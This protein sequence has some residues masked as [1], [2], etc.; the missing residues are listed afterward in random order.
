M[1]Q[2]LFIIHLPLFLILSIVCF[3]IPGVFLLEKIKIK[4]SFWEKII[5]G[6][7]I[8][9]IFFTLLS[10]SLL[11][12][13][14]H[15][16]LLPA[17]FSINLFAI[18]KISSLLNQIKFL[19]KYNLII[20]SLVFVIGVI[21]QLL[22]IA[23]S[24]IYQNGD[25]VFWSS[26]G[27][28]GLWHISLMEE[29]KK[30]YPL[31][32]PSLSGE[33]L[34]NYHFFSDIAPAEFNRYFKVPPLDLYF[35]FF[36]FIFS[37]LLGSLAYLLGKKMGGS[38][39]S[40]LWSVIFTYF[41]GSFGYIV[42]IM[43]NRTIGGES[44][45]WSS[46]PQ[47]SIGNP[48]QI[49]AFVIVL[50]FLYLFS[51]FVDKGGKVLLFLCALLAGSLA[52][53]KIYGATVLLISLFLVGLWQLFRERKL[54]LLFIFLMSSILA[55][56][57]YFPNSSNAGSFLIFEP[58]WFIRTMVVA[59]DRLNWLDL[60]LKRQTYIFESNWKRVV[61]V[62]LT[63]FVIFFFGN[64][65][66]R[67]L[68]LWSFWKLLRSFF[69]NYFNQL[70]LTIIIVS[71]LLPLL[72]LQKGVATNTI[73]FLQYFLL[74]F[75]ILASLTVNDI[76][77]KV[78]LKFLDLLLVVIIIL[79]SVPTQLAL[80]IS[81]YNRLPFAK[82]SAN[83]LSALKFLKDNITD[84]SIVLTAPYNKY[85]DL[86]DPIPNIW[87]WSDTS[88]VAAFT[89]R[90]LYIEDLE[91]LDI[92]GY[93]FQKRLKLQKEVF[94]TDDLITLREILKSN[95]IDYLYFPK[96]I[97]PN[98]DLSQLLKKTFENQQVEIW[99]TVPSTQ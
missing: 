52:G 62:E 33:K 55:A 45:F 95:R 66:M 83:E 17:I 41:A 61:Q 91:Q 76:F 32:N 73:Q 29:Y 6:T 39:A 5:L 58:W 49:A 74:L 68:G 11:I 12:L 85:L 50:A 80:I 40:G 21:G 30:G 72:F 24:G 18:K 60:E 44:I 19:P 94:E 92:M 13:R 4:L 47:S 86:H 81:F 27:H 8:G 79:L 10:Y 98:A 77:K 99:S 84:E 46:Q 43:Q 7:I 38:F 71:I 23:P 37:I 56:V 31:Q 42:T 1:P 90:R 3:T 2:V 59:P 25:L 54:H 88:Y 28:D 93:D 14:L 53:F 96:K 97:K 26:H 20:L 65:G 75:G 82:V 34:V 89:G 35:R 16:L 51:I 70:F 57:I 78:R 64:L 36:P 63:A 87:D 48:P 69:T 67:F 9:F 22:I 15:F